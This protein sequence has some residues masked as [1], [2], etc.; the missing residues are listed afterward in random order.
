L[1]GD[2]GKRTILRTKLE[3]QGKLTGLDGTKQI[4]AGNLRRSNTLPDR[5]IVDAAAFK[6]ANLFL[7]ASMR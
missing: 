3:N 1:N 5:R 4:H 2:I 6:W 7:P